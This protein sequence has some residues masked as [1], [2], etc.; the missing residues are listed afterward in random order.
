MINL[1]SSTPLDVTRLP[2]DCASKF[3]SYLT[4]VD[5][6]SF[7]AASLSTLR[8]AT[9]EVARR[10]KI[11]SE[12]LVCSPTNPRKWRPASEVPRVPSTL[13][14]SDD[15]ETIL[16]SVYERIV[17]LHRSLPATHRL[18][19]QARL[20]MEELE[21]ADEDGSNAR[22]PTSNVPGEEVVGPMI[23]S[24]E[25]FGERLMDLRIECRA[26]KIHAAMAK[27]IMNGHH[28]ESRY[29]S[30]RC[31]AARNSAGRTADSDPEIVVTLDDYM[32]D[33]FCAYYLM[34]H[35]AAG[36]V[37]GG[38]SEER[39]MDIIS[40]EVAADSVCTKSWYLA[41]VFMHSALLR[42]APFTERQ[43]SLLGLDPKQERN[44]DARGE[45]D[46]TKE[47]PM[48]PP[49]LPF[50]GVNKQSMWYCMQQFHV[51]LETEA[52]LKVKLNDF[53]PLGPT[54]RGRDRIRNLLIRPM[55]IIGALVR[56][57]GPWTTKRCREWREG[58]DPCVRWMLEMHAEASKTRPMTVAAPTVSIERTIE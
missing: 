11:L 26:H 19:A 4:L 41:W 36:I 7:G 42:T 48:I 40:Y 47:S 50:M 3:L 52:L 43:R 17:N 27:S 28:H 21:P 22:L 12:P 34:G 9:R 18:T 20:L 39:W 23:E 29:D 49:A 14:G 45:A 38:P 32:G 44:T 51:N 25:P 31:A 56:L 33:V 24:D 53:G 5:V 55:T 15:D 16:P 54:F 37:E 6:L 10:K 8:D 58:T 30:W 1:S 46:G 13:P 35:S 57:D 2:P